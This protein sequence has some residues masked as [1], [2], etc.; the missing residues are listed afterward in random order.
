VSLTIDG[1]LPIPYGRRVHLPGRGTTFVRELDGPPGA[2][3]V[4]LVHGWIASGGLNWF[5]TFGP[6]AERYHVIAPD[7]RG[8][9]RGI[10]SRRRFRLADCADD[11]AALA[12]VLKI[13][14]AIVVGYSLGG[15]VAQLVWRRHPELVDGLV[16]AATGDCFVDRTRDRV[17]FT[18][19][20]LAAAGLAGGAGYALGI[21]RVGE[22]FTPITRDRGRARTIERWALDEMRRHD[23]RTVFSAGR[24]L[25]SY[26]ARAWI[27][28]ID[29]PTAVLVTMGD[30]ALPPAGQLAFAG[31]I[32]G[33]SVHPIEG[34][35]T[36]CAST[37][38]AVPLVQACRSVAGRI[39]GNLPIV[40]ARAAQGR[41]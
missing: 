39:A 40:N 37:A 11:I 16:L 4:I 20:M 24:A 34:G 19:M 38:F 18:S 27:G 1:E 5:T 29:V 23:W 2:P 31:R 33:A 17:I 25:G 28:S 13:D 14:S 9:G 6:L 7:L 35:H 22:R 3:T 36:I 10:R 15:P 41:G 30:S 12:A 8:H 32:P 26:D 21:P